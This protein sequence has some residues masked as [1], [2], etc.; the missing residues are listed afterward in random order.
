M[1]DINTTLVIDNLISGKELKR[2]YSE[3]IGISEDEY[4]LR[5]FFGGQEIKD[6][7]FLYQYN[8]QKGF[9]IQVMKIPKK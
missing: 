6:S 8:L 5:L 1:S 3:K 4:N 9:K 2:L 7:N